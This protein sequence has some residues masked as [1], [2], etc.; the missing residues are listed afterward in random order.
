MSGARPAGTPSMCA[1]FSRWSFNIILYQPRMTM[2]PSKATS[3]ASIEDLREYIDA[4][5]TSSNRARYAIYIVIIATVLVWIVNRNA[6][7]DSWPLRR[8]QSYYGQELFKQPFFNADTVVIK[9]VREEYLKQFVARNMMPE[10]PLPGVSIDVNDLGIVGGIALVLLML[11][12][13]LSLSREHENLHLA[14]Y[15]VRQI[16]AEEG[17]NCSHGT[18][19]ANLL[20]HALA[21]SQVLSAPPTLARWHPHRLRSFGVVFAAP[22][23]VQSWVF[24]TNFETRH[25]GDSYGKDVTNSLI[26]QGLTVVALLALGTV[27]GLSSR[28]KAARWRRAFFRVNP[29]RRVTPQATARAWLRIPYL[30]LGRHRGDPLR[31]RV[32][33]ALTDTVLIAKPD[34]KAQVTAR[35][36]VRPVAPWWEPWLFWRESGPVQIRRTDVQRMAAKLD[37]KGH[38]AAREWCHQHNF[39]PHKVRLISFEAHQNVYEIEQSGAR[40]NRWIVQGNWTFRVNSDPSRPA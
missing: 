26:V 23:I 33:T 12:V 31:T 1:R 9:V 21:M 27:A 36:I 32:V 28:A 13:V 34:I 10:S 14:L 5:R 30:R 40:K 11:V 20:Y 29:S 2:N 35:H 37:Q 18:S 17:E 19:R 15:K 4:F 25:L 38:A 39:V 16:C 24:W 6:R 3:D 8:I 7:Q 22:G